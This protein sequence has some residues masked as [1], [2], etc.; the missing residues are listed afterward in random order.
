[1]ETKEVKTLGQLAEFINECEDWSLEVSG[2]IEANR[3]KDI[4]GEER[5]VCLCEESN[6]KVVLNDEGEAVIERI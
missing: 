6:E 2:I 1:M 3:W 5:G 4:T